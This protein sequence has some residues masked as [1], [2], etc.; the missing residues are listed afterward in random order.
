MQVNNCGKIVLG[1][2]NIQYVY[3]TEIDIVNFDFPLDIE[4]HS[5]PNVILLDG[6]LWKTIPYTFDSAEISF[7]SISDKHDD[8]YN[9]KIKGELKFNSK[10]S[11]PALNQLRDRFVVLKIS[12]GGEEWI[13][14]SRDYPLKLALS[15]LKN[16]SR[17]LLL[18]TF[19]GIVNYLPPFIAS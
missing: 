1:V 17:G 15:G 6:K 9:I 3:H 13:L 16:S 5:I 18:P 14:G 2:T 10:E 12:H 8:M 11:I 7:S 4:T 19:K